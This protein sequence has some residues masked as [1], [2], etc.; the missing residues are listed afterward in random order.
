MPFALLAASGVEILH[1]DGWIW[2]AAGLS[3]SISMVVGYGYVV[4]VRAIAMGMTDVA[5]RPSVADWPRVGVS[6]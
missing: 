5:S 3:S 6:R 1:V 4:L 2:V